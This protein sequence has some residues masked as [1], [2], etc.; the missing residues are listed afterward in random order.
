MYTDNID[1]GATVTA[2]P[3]AFLRVISPQTEIRSIGGSGTNTVFEAR[4]APSGN[5]NPEVRRARRA[6]PTGVCGTGLSWCP[7]LRGVL[8]CVDTRTDIF[9][10][11]PL[12]LEGES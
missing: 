12:T 9:S 2:E 6:Q 3:G 5:V 7:N 10:K 1:I 8:G 11:S 4:L